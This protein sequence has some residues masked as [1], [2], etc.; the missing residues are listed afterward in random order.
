MHHTRFCFVLLSLCSIW[1]AGCGNSSSS[2]APTTATG[3]K[4]IRICMLPKIKG[5]SYFSSCYEGAKRA[6]AEL[7]NVE[8]IYDGPID[9]DPKKQA[10]MIERWIV[11]KVDVICVAPS[12]PD[13]VANAMKDARAAGI[14]V[15]TWDA[16]GAVDSRQ[17]FINQATPAS[18]GKGMVAV[19]VDNV[20]GPDVTGDVVIVSSDPTSANQN[21]WIDVMKPALEATKL[22]LVTIKYPGEN[23]SNALADAQDVIKKYPNLKGIFG[24]SSVSFPGAAEAVEQSG[25]GGQI[26]VTGLST[27]TPMKRFID[28]GT[29]KSIVLWNT[30][31]LGYLTVRVAEGLATG[32]LK[33]SDSECDAGSLGSKPIVDGHVLLGDILVFTKDNIDQ[34]NF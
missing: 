19:M 28:S 30:L 33:P 4:K 6:A 29:V 13:V 17:L 7:P 32:K 5:I 34:Y 31:D 22:K 15:I 8:L 16:D 27:P 23:A 25:K 14:H 21:A 24:I 9:G 12:A 20:G 18:I 1:S 10:E 2:S 3:E 26:M 11:D